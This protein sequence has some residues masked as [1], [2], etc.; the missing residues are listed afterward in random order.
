[1]QGIHQLRDF[2]GLMDHRLERYIA[3]G[4]SSR[5]LFVGTATSGVTKAKWRSSGYGQR[6]DRVDGD[7]RDQDNAAQQ[8]R[9][10]DYQRGSR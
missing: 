5:A 3:A 9:R 6:L 4:G 10:R 2:A 1:M 8:T 7:A